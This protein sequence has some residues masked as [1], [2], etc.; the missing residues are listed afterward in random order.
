LERVGVDGKRI[1]KEGLNALV[2]ER[3]LE[4]SSAR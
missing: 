4:I 3:G 1:L 2:G